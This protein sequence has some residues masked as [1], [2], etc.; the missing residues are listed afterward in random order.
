[1]SLKLSDGGGHV[2]EVEE[3][4][5]GFRNFRKCKWSGRGV[6]VTDDRLADFR[7]IRAFAKNRRTLR[8]VAKS[9]ESESDLRLYPMVTLLT[10]RGQS[11]SAT[12]GARDGLVRGGT[13]KK[14][15]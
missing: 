7:K 8:K 5:E 1:M 11:V 3:L 13:P 2:V 9:A 15:N 14:G 10:I 12:A 4:V 6:R